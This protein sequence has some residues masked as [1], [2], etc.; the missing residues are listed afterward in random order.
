M[1]K[2]GKLLMCVIIMVCA[3]AGSLGARQIYNVSADGTS[4]IVTF[5]Y[6]T[7]KIVEYIPEN[8]T[9]KNSLKTYSI[10]VEDGGFAVETSKP[11][12]LLNPYYSYEWTYNGSVVDLSTF[13]ITRDTTFVASWTA[14]QYSINFNF[15]S[16]EVKNKIAN[17][18]TH[19][20]FSVESPRINLY[21]PILEH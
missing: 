4:H 14:K 18:Q 17:L 1:K 16:E 10:T 20:F 8:S 15:E 5:N 3:V 13:Q 2:F 6:N 12:S 21:R 7:K 19:I 11:S 9:I